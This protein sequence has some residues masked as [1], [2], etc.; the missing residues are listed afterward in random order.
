[1]NEICRDASVAEKSLTGID[2]SPKETVSDAIERAAMT[3]SCDDALIDNC[4]DS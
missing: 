4:F 2:T 3:D 1:L